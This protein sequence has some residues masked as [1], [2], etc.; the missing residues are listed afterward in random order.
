MI[1]SCYATK[2][3]VDKSVAERQ[4]EEHDSSL[5]VDTSASERTDTEE[6]NKTT[7]KFGA[8]RKAAHGHRNRQLLLE[9]IVLDSNFAWEIST[10]ERSHTTSANQKTAGNGATPNFTEAWYGREQRYQ[11]SLG[12][13]VAHITTRTD[14]GWRSGHTIPSRVTILS[15]VDIF[16]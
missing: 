4:P 9:A 13:L 15:R 7:C 11:R 14:T 16:I 12:S 5:D 2:K 8:K 3:P 1:S 6:T 10:R